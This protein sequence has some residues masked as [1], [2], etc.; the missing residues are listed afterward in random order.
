VQSL[1]TFSPEKLRSK[2]APYMQR[3]YTHQCNNRD[4]FVRKKVCK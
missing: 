3:D 2:E 4:C 1:V